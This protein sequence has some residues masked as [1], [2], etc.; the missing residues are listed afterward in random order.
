MSLYIVESSE[1]ERAAVERAPVG[2]LFYNI[3]LQ[4]RT[5]RAMIPLTMRPLMIMSEILLHTRKG[6]PIKQPV[7]FCLTR[8]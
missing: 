4:P 1:T 3:F 2:V 5:I 7:S 8:V 6:S